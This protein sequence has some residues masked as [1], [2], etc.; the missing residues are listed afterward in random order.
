MACFPVVM[1]PMI[2][3]RQLLGGDLHRLMRCAWL[4]GD[5]ICYYLELV[6]AQAGYVILSAALFG[7]PG[8]PVEA[9]IRSHR[10]DISKIKPGTQL[11]LFFFS[12]L[13]LSQSIILALPVCIFA[14][15]VIACKKYTHN[16]NI[17]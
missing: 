17:I 4:T 12:L 15:F 14:K 2:G 10:A 7:T 8:K 9:I 13:M 5:T 3:H 1:Y 6:C 16:K 11:V